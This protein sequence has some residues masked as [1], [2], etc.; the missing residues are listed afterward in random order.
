MKISSL[1]ECEYAGIVAIYNMHTGDTVLDK[2]LKSRYTDAQLKELQKKKD[3]KNVGIE[4]C[5]L[6]FTRPLD[7][8][9][10]EKFNYYYTLF[11][12]YEK[13][14]MPFP[15][16]VSEQPAQ[17]IEIFNVFKALRSE[18]DIKLS[19]QIKKEN[20]RYKG[21]NKSRSSR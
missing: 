18:Q 14:V 6:R 9:P 15:G 16:S 7:L 13:G 20:G 21:N 3:E 17:I 12:N 1:H 11:E 8:F 2:E 4:S 10:C 19:K 5:G